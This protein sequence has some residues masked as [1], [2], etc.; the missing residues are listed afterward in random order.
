MA[1]Y[2]PRSLVPAT[3]LENPAD[4]RCDEHS[5]FVDGFPQPLAGQPRAWVPLWGG[6]CVVC[7]K[8]T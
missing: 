5:T 8:P 2:N 3:A 4:V 7:Q 1:T 6:P